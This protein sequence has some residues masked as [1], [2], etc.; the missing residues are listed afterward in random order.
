MT[1]EQ[2]MENWVDKYLAA[3]PDEKV[4]DFSHLYEQAD[5]AWYDQE[6]EAGKVKDTPEQKAAMR[7]AR[8][9]I[10]AVDAYGKTKQRTRKEDA[11]KQAIIAA[12]VPVLREMGFSPSVANAERQ[13]DFGVYSLTLTKHRAPKVN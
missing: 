9:G 1:K 7:E 6:V 12:L 8:K 11:E 10:T 13:I 2:F 4:S 3:H 5:C